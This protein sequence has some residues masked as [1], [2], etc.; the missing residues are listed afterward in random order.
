VVWGVEVV[1]FAA[2]YKS[3]ADCTGVFP[4]V[5]GLQEVQ[6]L[7]RAGFFGLIFR[8]NRAACIG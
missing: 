4:N 3:W 6:Q 1:G 2:G 7:D 5:E 8:S